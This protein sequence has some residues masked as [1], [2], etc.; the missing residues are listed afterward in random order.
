MWTQC[1]N[2]FN[3]LIKNSAI[4]SYQ[5]LNL[6]DFNGPFKWHFTVYM[7]LIKNQVMVIKTQRKAVFNYSFGLRL[8]LPSL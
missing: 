1:K 6:I 2:L 8:S 3:K 4:V 5:K 7:A